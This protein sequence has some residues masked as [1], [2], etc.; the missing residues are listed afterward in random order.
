MNNIKYIFNQ[1]IFKE[2]MVPIII[3]GI[4]VIVLIIIAIFL[5]NKELREEV[6]ENEK[7][8]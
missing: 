4:V 5:T 3:L 1:V 6:R 7:N 8:N 2:N